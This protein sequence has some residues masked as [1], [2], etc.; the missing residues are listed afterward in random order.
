M[1]FGAKNAFLSVDQFTLDFDIDVAHGQSGSAIFSANVNQPFFGY[2]V[3]I[4]TEGHPTFNSGTRIDSSLLLDILTGCSVMNCSISAYIEN[5]PTVTPEPAPTNSPA[6]TAVPTHSPA[7]TPSHLPTPTPPGGQIEGDLNCDGFVSVADVTLGLRLVAG[8]GTSLQCNAAADVDCNGIANG[9]DVLDL[10]RFVV[11]LQSLITGNCP[12]IGGHGA[13]SPSATVMPTHTPTPTPTPNSPTPTAHTPTPTPHAVTP[14]PHTST[15]TPPVVG[16]IQAQ[17][18]TWYFDSIGAIHVVGEVNNAT[19][20]T[21]DFI[22][23]TASF[24]SANNQ[25]LA[26]DFGYS[27]LNAVGPGGLSPFDVLLL[28]PPS[29]IDHVTVGVTD[30]YSP[31]LSYAVPP[32]LSVTADNSYY[33]IV[34]VLHLVGTV[35][36]HSSNTY[37]F[38]K[39][40]YATYNS[41]G[42]VVTTGSWY[43]SPSTLG[44]NQTGTYDALDFDAFYFSWDHWEVWPDAS[45]P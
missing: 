29:G 42:S 24:Y 36:N 2:I 12:A 40:C 19:N 15:P 1:W 39:A 13:G 23:I 16:N 17:H 10:L 9:L 38:V 31:P 11:H 41:S 30:Y 22:K 3:G 8:L 18:S 33:D 14:T 20:S 6:H 43:T 34:D 44:P 7:P 32:G 21:A 35:T 5:G 4:V 26:T 25:L 37:D 27:C 45:Y 28:S